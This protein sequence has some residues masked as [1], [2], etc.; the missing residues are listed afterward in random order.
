MIVRLPNPLAEAVHRVQEIQRKIL[1]PFE[2][3]RA[4]F[5]FETQVIELPELGGD[6]TQEEETEE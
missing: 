3:V 2:R 4:R 1:E 6:E 5:A